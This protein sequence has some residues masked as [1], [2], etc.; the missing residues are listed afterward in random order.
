MP[1]PIEE[2]YNDGKHW[3]ARFHEFQTD[4]TKWTPLHRICTVDEAEFKPKKG[5]RRRKRSQ[6]EKIEFL[7]DRKTIKRMEL[8]VEW[9]KEKNF[10]EAQTPADRHTFT[11][12]LVGYR[13][14][15]LGNLAAKTQTEYERYLEYWEGIF[16]ELPV[17][18]I[19]I[20]R[21]IEEQDKLVDEPIQREFGGN[22]NGQI[23]SGFTVNRY[24]A[25]LSNVF[26]KTIIKHKRWM[27]SNP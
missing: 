8:Q 20:D 14:R 13:K 25:T 11:E 12:A 4:P 23:R 15:V 9:E 22:G 16:G 2:F 1:K 21:L 18:Q 10:R 19:T 17:S 27:M 5:N 6:L 3:R 26:T 7:K 24:F